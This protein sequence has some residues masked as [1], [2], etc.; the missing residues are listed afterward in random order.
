MKSACA[1]IPGLSLNLIEPVLNWLG[2]HPMTD[3]FKIALVA[4]VGGVTGGLVTGF[5][6]HA[7]AWF[8]RPR[9]S[10][11]YANEE[12]HFIDFNAVNW[13][14][15]D[16]SA[17]YVR[18]RVRNEGR[19]VAKGCRVFLT[20]LDEVHP[21]GT[22]PTNLP[23]ALVLGWPG[24]H[25]FEPRDI[26]RGISFY[27]DLVMVSKHIEGWGFC[28]KEIYANQKHLAQYRGT[29]RFHVLVTADDADPGQ[30]R[31]DASYDGDWHN[32]RAVP[33]R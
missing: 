9:L 26:P 3:E 2:K 14:G 28:V 21:S 30:C 10:V 15:R 11:D 24:G 18:V 7:R 16:I 19:R 20:G 13:E 25:D 17:V 5:Y 27:A 1:A 29:Y 12:R 22:T 32:F 23:D 4:A 6:S 31:V 8:T 33:V